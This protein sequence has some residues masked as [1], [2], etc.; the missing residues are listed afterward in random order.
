MGL[1]IIGHIILTS[2]IRAGVNLR[3]YAYLM[4]RSR[5]IIIL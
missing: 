4:T 2:K 3:P 5:F 1:N